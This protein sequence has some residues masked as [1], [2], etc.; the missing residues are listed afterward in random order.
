[1]CTGDKEDLPRFM[2]LATCYIDPF[3]NLFYYMQ[4]NIYYLLPEKLDSLAEGRY[5]VINAPGSQIQSESE[6]K[7]MDTWSQIEDLNIV[8]RIISTCLS[9]RVLTKIVQLNGS[10]A[11][12]S[13]GRTLSMLTTSSTASTATRNLPSSWLKP[14]LEP[15]YITALYDVDALAEGD[16]SFKTGDRIKV[17]TKTDSQEDWWAGCLPQNPSVSA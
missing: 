9:P 14:K 6:G 3:I 8:K 11:C 16:L 15:E 10:A 13:V 7:W 2:Q 4:P 12:P 1:M 17:I 5:D